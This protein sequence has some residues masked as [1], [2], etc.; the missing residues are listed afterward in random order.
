MRVV[1]VAA[2]LAADSRE[3]E[4]P[5]IF[6]D[7]HDLGDVVRAG[8]ELP[9][10][11]AGLGVVQ[12]EVTPAVSWRIPDDLRAIGDDP[13]VDGSPEEVGIDGTFRALFH[14]GAGGARCGVDF[15]QS[16]P[17]IAAIARQQKDPAAVL[18]ATR[19]RSD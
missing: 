3:V 14:H 13:D 15:V 8:R 6:V 5:A 7:V 12:V 11:R 9:E 16:I 10:Q 1:R 17:E 4:P 2:L 19:A 18:R